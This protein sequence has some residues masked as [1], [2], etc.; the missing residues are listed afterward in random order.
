MG[1]A[2]EGVE[3]LHV[4][5]A[6]H[7]MVMCAARQVNVQDVA[8]RHGRSSYVPPVAV[9]DRTRIPGPTILSSGLLAA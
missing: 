2:G 5:D 9:M 1:R 4:G 8:L 6:V 7:C 3:D